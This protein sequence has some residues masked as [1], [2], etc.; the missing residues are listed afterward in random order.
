MLAGCGGGSSK[1]NAVSDNST[2]LTSGIITGFGSVYINGIKFETDHANYDID[3]DT[4]A[5][6]SDLR[7]GMKIKIL[8]SIND[9]GLT[10]TA[11]SITY[12]NELEGPVSAVDATTDFPNVLLTILGQQITVTTDTTFDNDDNALD[13]NSIQVN[14]LLEVSGYIGSTGIIATHI[15][16]QEGSFD[17]DNPE[18][19]EVEIKGRI[20][21]LT[22]S[23][24]SVNGL[25][26]SYTSDTELEDVPGNILMDDMLV[27]VKGSLNETADTLIATKIEAEDDGFDE[28][29]DDVEIE[30]LI[31]DYDPETS[32]FMVQGQMVQLT[33]D[34]ELTPSSLVLVN[35][36]KIEVEGVVVNDILIAEKIKLKGRKIKIHAAISF[37]DTDEGTVSFSLF[38]DIDNITVRVNEQ[39][40]MEDDLAQEDSIFTLADLVEGDFVEVEAFDDGTSII[41]AIELERKEADDFQLEGPITDYDRDLLTVTL[42]GQKFELP[43]IAKFEGENGVEFTLA[44]DFFDLLSVGSFIELTDEVPNEGGLPDGSID[45]VEIEEED[46]DD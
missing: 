11:D 24:F 18:L 13:M 30:G 1:N 9:D 16:K 6:Q 43:D 15:E 39:T 35:D 2:T 44:S 26:V 10:G 3:D 4:S 22:E 25:D 31:T 14:D 46:D 37:I 19:S 21:N 41:N 32:T 36:L 33:D 45:K 12:E 38:G 29:F 7:V 8:G 40:D 20:E 42:F 28:E 34:T 23:S 17:A 5:D 27:E